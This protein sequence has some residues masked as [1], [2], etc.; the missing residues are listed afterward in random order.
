MRQAARMIGLFFWIFLL[1][2]SGVTGA[3]LF[4]WTDANEVIHFTDNLH[5]VPQSVRDSAKLVIRKD[6]LVSSKPSHELNVTAEPIPPDVKADT[7]KG[8]GTESEQS[9]PISITYSPQEVNIVVVNSNVRRPKIRA[10]SANHNCRPI[11]RPAFNNR[12]YIHPSVFDGGSR[13]YIHP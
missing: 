2:Q 13:Q 4:Q 10:C 3:D 7:Q 8:S 12:Q 9:E 1:T 11:F 5:N 6:Y